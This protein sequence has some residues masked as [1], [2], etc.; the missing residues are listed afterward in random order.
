LRKALDVTEVQAQAILDMQLRR[1]A[2]LERKKIEEEHKEKIRLIKYLE[3][4]LQSPRQM[5]AVIAEEVSTI[6]QAY[7]DPRRTIIVEGSARDVAESVLHVPQ[8]ETWATLTVTGK[9]GRTR[10]NTP[11]KVTGDVKEPPRFILE[12]DASEL[13]YLFTAKGTCSTIPVYTLLQVN[14]PPEGARSHS[15]CALD[16][17]DEDVPV[18][19]LQVDIETRFRI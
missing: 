16:A 4:L 1:L 18:V 6:K 15:L 5:R 12:T 11:P 17:Q 3:G 8:E 10:E 9:L 19:A 7:G 2:A 14:N 13:L